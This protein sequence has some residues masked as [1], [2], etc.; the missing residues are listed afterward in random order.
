[1]TDRELFKYDVRVRERFVAEGA[2]TKSDLERHLSALADVAEQC[3]E[4]ELEQPALSKEQEDAVAAETP[5]GLTG[6]EA[7]KPGEG[8]GVAA[9]PAIQES[10]APVSPLA[11]ATTTPARESLPAIAP[12]SSSA[13]PPAAEPHGPASVPPP[14]ASVDADWGDS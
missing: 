6:V 2:I 3:E 9:I 12:E 10:G 14:T 7:P 8:A 4:V 5:P 11:A 13:Q 1:M